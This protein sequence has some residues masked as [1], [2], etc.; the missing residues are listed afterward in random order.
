MYCIKC[1]A[2]LPSH[3]ETCPSCGAP[4]DE[5]FDNDV[6]DETLIGFS[7]KIDDPA[8][9][10]H[11]KKSRRVTI[12]FGVVMALVIILGAIIGSYFGSVD[13]TSGT[14]LFTV[15]FLAAMFLIVSLW[16]GG[17]KGRGRTWDG[18][19]VD[20]TSA[21]RRRSNSNSK[22]RSYTYYTEYVVKFKEDNGK[23]HKLT[24]QNNDLYYNYFNI[25]DK[26]RHHG[27]LN[28]YEKYDKSK[29]TYIICN[30]CS[31]VCSISDDYC[32]HCGCPLLK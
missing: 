20:K 3:S 22:D 19:V 17:T 26:V 23:K 31:A 2:K 10:E 4:Q 28:S 1:G 18:T 9:D 30:A 14:T 27:K 6:V 24:T 8:F 15:L 12:I 29:D 13:L 25:G 11:I 32:P 7:N 16:I 5:K 21:R